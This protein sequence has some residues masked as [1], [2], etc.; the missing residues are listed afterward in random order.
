MFWVKIPPPSIKIRSHTTLARSAGGKRSSHTNGLFSAPS[1]SAALTYIMHH[2]QYHFVYNFPWAAT[3]SSFKKWRMRW[4]SMNG[5]EPNS[6]N[7]TR[8]CNINT[9]M[10]INVYG[11]EGNM[12]P[13]LQTVYLSSNPHSLSW[14]HAL[15][16]TRPHSLN[17]DAPITS[18]PVVRTS[19]LFEEQKALSTHTHLAPA[20]L[21]VENA[22]TFVK[23]VD[24]KAPALEIC[25][26]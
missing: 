20:S 16:L 19:H 2:T 1:L 13:P 9:S 6:M 5:M 7:W 17:S 12:L 3:I 26:F 18:L 23:S 10:N 21:S 25:V 8:F 22:R 15:K 11:C 4:S 24:Y 14:T